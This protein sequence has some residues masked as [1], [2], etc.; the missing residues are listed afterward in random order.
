MLMALLPLPASAQSKDIRA[1]FTVDGNQEKSQNRSHV[2]LESVVTNECV[3]YEYGGA[4]LYMR[5]VRMN[6]TAGSSNDTD[7]ENT[8]SNSAFL[9]AQASKAELLQCEANCHTD[10][11]FGIAAKDNGTSINVIE[12]KTTVSKE[13]S[14]GIYAVAGAGI[15]VSDHIVQSHSKNSPAIGTGKDGDIEASLLTGGT[16]GLASPI[17]SSRGRI[18]ATECKMNAVSAPIAYVRDDGSL[19]LVKCELEQNGSCGFL[20]FDGNGPSGGELMIA[21]CKLDINDG[22]LFVI[23]GNNIAI[24]SS[25]NAISLSDDCLMSIKGGKVTLKSSDEKLK[26]DI[27][28]DGISSLS[29]TMGKGMSLVSAI[30]KDNNPEAKVE[31]TI[32][33]GST[34]QTTANSHVAAISF[35]AGVEK[36]LK[37]IKGNYDIIY[38]AGNP[39]NS[40]LGGKEYETGGKG[41]LKPAR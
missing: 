35:E 2:S 18:R 39:V 10:K 37:Q 38:D 12:G 13:Q 19:E 4:S 15:T 34:W 31:I 6:K 26:G 3:V 29:L 36:G 16:K 5:S 28:M 32:G 27:V 14:I 11:T 24:T 40:Y 21:D 41:K 25:G 23:D 1:M 30:N 7:R 33:K 9:A 17:F 20:I 8:C 22:P